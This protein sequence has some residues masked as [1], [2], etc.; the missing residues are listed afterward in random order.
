MTLRR[1]KHDDTV[2]Y[3]LGMTLTIELLLAH[4]QKKHTP[5]EKRR[6]YN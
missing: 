3:T 5:A 2:S 4:P 6:D 1:Y